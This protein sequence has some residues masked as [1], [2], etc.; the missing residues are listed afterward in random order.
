[1]GERNEIELVISGIAGC[2]SY[3]R[4]KRA[5]AIKIN[6]FPSFGFSEINSI[7]KPERIQEL[8]FVM[9]GAVIMT[10]KWNSPVSRKRRLC[11]NGFIKWR[12]DRKGK[13]H[14]KT[15]ELSAY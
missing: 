2:P 8:G 7:E 14:E 13:V 10:G 4:V 12:T 11:G 3:S 9:T 5:S 15:F 1:M 6:D